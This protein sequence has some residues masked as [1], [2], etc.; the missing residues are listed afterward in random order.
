METIQY[1]DP[2]WVAM[3]QFDDLYSF[4]SVEH[5]HPT[6]DLK[7]RMKTK[8]PWPCSERFK[9]GGTGFTFVQNEIRQRLYLCVGE[10]ETYPGIDMT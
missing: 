6:R 2:I 9:A 3:I 10:G 5:L 1:D 8:T 7:S 4:F